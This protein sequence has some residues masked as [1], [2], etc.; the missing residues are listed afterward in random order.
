M[1]ELCLV[2]VRTDKLRRNPNDSTHVVRYTSRPFVRYLGT[3][4]LISITV[5]FTY[6]DVICDVDSSS[7][8]SQ[9]MYSVSV[10]I[11]SCCVQGSVLMERKWTD[12][13][14]EK[15]K[16]KVCQMH[17][18]IQIGECGGYI[19]IAWHCIYES[20]YRVIT[21]VSS[22]VPFTYPFN[23]FN[24]HF[25]SFLNQELHCAHMAPVCCPV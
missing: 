9:I 6:P 7:I 5:S 20:S 18:L 24:V 21:T 13:K 22:T 12:S 1:W 23:I 2:W 8:V 16:F 10:A 4:N 14:H 11:D 3:Q 19:I 17:N 15:I 25:S